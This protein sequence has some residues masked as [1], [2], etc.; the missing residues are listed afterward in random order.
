MLFPWAADLDQI[1]LTETLHHSGYAILVMNLFRGVSL[2]LLR[3]WVHPAYRRTRWNVRQAPACFRSRVVANS[4]AL[5]AADSLEPSF[6]IHHS[7]TSCLHWCRPGTSRLSV[8]K[9]S[10]CKPS[11]STC[12]A[13]I[14]PR[15]FVVIERGH[16]TQRRRIGLP[17]PAHGPRCCC[18]SR[19]ART[20]FKLSSIVLDSIN[21][22]PQGEDRIVTL[23]F[24]C[25]SETIA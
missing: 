14:E 13:I 19:Q 15:P 1:Q 9:S 6:S 7:P 8:P 24:P 4:S 25:K 5:H 21:S 11:R 16:I 3:R 10:A 17:V 22:P 20:T 2:D 23:S 18:R 12:A